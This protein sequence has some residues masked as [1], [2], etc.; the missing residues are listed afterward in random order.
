MSKGW[1][2]KLNSAQQQA[3]EA[4]S[5][6]CLVLAGAG[7]GKTRV[8]TAKIAYLID[9]QR[10]DPARICA[11]TFTNKAAVEMSDRVAASI[12]RERARQVRISTF[13]SLGLDILRREHSSLGL[14]R[15]FSLFNEADS[16]KIVGDILREDLPA[17]LTAGSESGEIENYTQR[18]ATFKSQLIK[19]D[20]VSDPK[21][22]EVYARY[23]TYLRSCNAVDFEDL[24]FKTTL[25]L[26]EN[27]TV[28]QRWL[29]W[30]QYVLV[31]EYQ[32][33]NETQYRL[34]RQLTS[35]CGRFTVVGDD[36]QSIY[37]WRGASPQNLERLTEDYPD[38]RVIKLEENYRCTQRILNC[39][40][41]LISHNRHLYNKTLYTRQP[42]G[43]R[44]S[45]WECTDE[46]DECGLVVAD[47]IHKHGQYRNAYSDYAVLYRSNAQ[48]RYFEKEFY[49]AHIP[50]TIS[51]GTSFFELHEVKDML[52]WSRV[53]CNPHDNVALL[54]VINVPRRGI[55]TELLT[56]LS[57]SSK[58]TGQSL[59]ATALDRYVVAKL[60]DSQKAALGEF[61]SL[62]V[63]L[64]K[65]LVDYK[66]LELAE[67]L[68]DLID[69]ERYLL[70]TYPGKPDLKNAKLNNARI[71]MGWISD[72]VSGKKNGLELSFEEAVGKLYL[73]E[74]L[75]RQ[76]KQQEVDAV[77]LL[78]LHAAKGLEFPY[79]Y[80]VGVEEDLL[81]HHNS[82]QSPEGLAEER[83]LCYV[84]ITRAK[85]E[86]SLS[87][88][89]K[90]GL[91][92]RQKEV[93]QSRFVAELA[94][95]DLLFQRT[96]DQL[97]PVRQ[98][99]QEGLAMLGDVVSEQCRLIAK[100]T[101]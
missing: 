88:C 98:S 94:Q 26:E 32:D 49:A 43:P 50:V 65:M 8:I 33:T 18:I 75:D 22:S 58:R 99:G 4:V 68:I 74:F 19:P 37:A 23:E 97:S 45:V 81:P 21:L 54:R 77:Q 42:P 69:Y 66:D 24:I 80:L 63:R 87:W 9:A 13:H 67:H 83:R 38:L 84:G 40:N 62:V 47:I 61:L 89:K 7:S 93:H 46:Q 16:R 55:G 64:R 5:G 101:D 20:E 2:V 53:V 60:T 44:I 3:V 12:G 96:S 31:D 92:E 72:F 36:D 10:L 29:P 79:V 59:Y 11:V 100:S 52:A 51:G 86:L 70:T 17:L 78:T 1:G 30:F 35:V 27:Q 34:L 39:A 91:G 6:P 56:L 15:N 73:R 85:Q 57:E 25:L 90:R 76:N 95:E 82:S 48:S 41:Q 28:S 14:G 71:F